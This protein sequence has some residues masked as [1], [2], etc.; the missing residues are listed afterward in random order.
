MYQ[1]ITSKATS[2]V[3]QEVEPAYV[4]TDL[5]KSPTSQP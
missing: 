4:Q 5:T 1:K 3:D 2:Q